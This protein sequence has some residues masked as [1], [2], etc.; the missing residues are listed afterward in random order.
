ME[1]DKPGSCFTFEAMAEV[2]ANRF[3]L[4]KRAVIRWLDLKGYTTADFIGK[5]IQEEIRRPEWLG[6]VLWGKHGIK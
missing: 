4:S 6:D 3:C 2:I 5:V 1:K